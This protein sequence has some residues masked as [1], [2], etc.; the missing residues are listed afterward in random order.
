MA[1]PETVPIYVT[2]PTAP[3]LMALPATFPV[4]PRVLV[5]DERT[6]VPLKFDPDCFQLSVKV[7]LK[8]PLYCPDQVPERSTV[9]TA[10]VGVAVGVLVGAGV[11][12]ADGAAVEGDALQAASNE[13]RESA[14]N[15]TMVRFISEVLPLFQ[16]LLTEA[17]Q[18]SRTRR[19]VAWPRARSRRKT[20]GAR[21]SPVRPRGSLGPVGTSARLVLR[22]RRRHPHATEGRSPE[23]AGTS[24]V[25]L[26]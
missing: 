3:K 24:W 13:T 1:L 6:M 26:A 21:G 19:R 14:A 20:L 4:M 5:G 12:V 17:Y 7:P 11:L 2:P 9:A 18:P 16:L 25:V 8:T 15:I 23:G 22:L 10:A